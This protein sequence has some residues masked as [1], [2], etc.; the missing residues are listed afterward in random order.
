MT[1]NARD[2]LGLRQNPM[3][4]ALL[5]FVINAIVGMYEAN[6]I[7]NLITNLELGLTQEL[8]NKYLILWEQIISFLAYPMDISK[9]IYTTNTI[10]NLNS[11]LRKQS[12]LGGIYP[13]I[14]QLPSNLYL[15]IN[16][17]TVKREKS[18]RG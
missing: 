16:N 8:C 11:T 12:R 14:R 15:A 1:D 9:V 13:M 3:R 5:A 6:F 17:L 18:P 10:E 4:A 7:D 2:T